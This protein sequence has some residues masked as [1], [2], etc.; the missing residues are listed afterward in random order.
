M[1]MRGV[2]TAPPPAHQGV[3]NLWERMDRMVSY[4]PM[5]CD[6]TWGAGGTTSGTR[7][8]G[9]PPAASPYCPHGRRR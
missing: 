8:G 2:Q 9:P 7:A 3:M 6:I 1:I 5:F 4:Q